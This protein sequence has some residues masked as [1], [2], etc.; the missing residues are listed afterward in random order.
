MDRIIEA[1]VDVCAINA[2]ISAGLCRAR[3]VLV[4]R[5]GFLGGMSTATS[6]YPL[7]KEKT[8]DDKGYTHGEMVRGLFHTR[9]QIRK[10][11]HKS[12]QQIYIDFDIVLLHSN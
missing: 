3:T 6:I 7:N 5:Y 11:K 12:F 8:S 4:E 1:D 10:R 9:C 2:A